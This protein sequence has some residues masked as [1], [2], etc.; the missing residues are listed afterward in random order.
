MFF[1][2]FHVLCLLLL[3]FRRIQ[4]LLCYQRSVNKILNLGRLNTSTAA[5]LARRFSR[6][7]PFLE[8]RRSRH[9]HPGCRDAALLASH[10]RPSAAADG[11]LL[12]ATALISN[13]LL[14][15]LLLAARALGDVHLGLSIKFA[16]TIQAMVA[17]D[18]GIQH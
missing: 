5:N 9:N 14:N 12:V 10:A 3:S 18:S 15:I 2:G 16:L 4:L 17:I 8:L 6:R 11:H 7:T 1:Q 13:D